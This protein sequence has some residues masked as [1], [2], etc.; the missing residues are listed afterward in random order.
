M[1]KLTAAFIIGLGL[2]AGV[3]LLVMGRT[4]GSEPISPT[5]R[6]IERSPY[7]TTA[8][9][10]QASGSQAKS[11]ADIQS[12]PS[13]FERRAA[14]YARLKSADV[15]AVEILLDEA[16]DLT[17]PRRVKQVIYSR[18]V[19]IDPRAALV[20]LRR[21]ERDQQLLVRTT[22]SAV[23]GSDLDAALAFI[24]TLDDS[25]RTQ[26][27]RNILDLEALS[28]ARKEE[29]AKRFGLERDLLQLQ[30]SRRAK[31]DPAGAWQ[32][33]LATERGDERNAM[34]WSV[35]EVWF[36]TDPL[37]TLSAIASLNAPHWRG[38]QS[39]LVHRW[40]SQDP[41]A[42]L[43]WALARPGSDRQSDPL[44]Q[45]AAE[46]AKH[47]PQEMFDL[48]ETLEPPRRNRV[49]E[50]VLFAWGRIDPVAAL[51]AAMSMENAAHLPEMVGVSI[52]DS[53]AGN[54]P[55][56][57][58][59]WV[60]AQAPSSARSSMLVAT[61][62]NLGESDPARALS[63]AEELDGNARSRSIESVLRTWGVRD[64]LA[65]AAWLDASG[66]K[67]S[68]AVVAVVH[69]FAEEDPVG[70]FEWLQD[71]PVAAQQHGFPI[72]VRQI[73][74]TSPE[75]ALRLI[76]RIRDPNAKQAAG[77][78]LISSWVET[79]PQ[80]AVRAIARMDETVGQPLYGYA[81]QMWSSFDPESATAFLDRIPSSQR[82]GA[83]QGMVQQAA[84][85]D[86][87]LAEQLFDRLKGDESRRAAAALLFR[88]LH[89]IDPE[90]A[91]RYRELSGI[92]GDPR[93]NIGFFR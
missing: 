39:T 44:G 64:P 78:Q 22:L 29:V 70:A 79:D 85:R 4:G 40:L 34:L 50:G 19:Q 55:Q 13:E 12:L 56:A 75:S 28:E 74:A 48:V 46:I 84:F 15:D 10:T 23:A 73:A 49:V 83:I 3:V 59:E 62:A 6:T 33:A 81:F 66:N 47:S 20:R 7:A 8:T 69:N 67:T 88:A 43:E 31:D 77:Y 41:D 38:L 61:L 86:P 37:A 80:E 87:D 14:L 71:Q 54:D 9:R 11:L 5:P 90:R 57:A 16:E 63:L 68:A 82:D 25:L 30:A 72:V 27:A 36:E 53:W 76:A 58:F 1:A 60:R 26:S 24:D 91:E 42:A 65:A 51:D 18:Y 21:E 92:T 45:V 35:A 89:E 2:G 17:S 93:I 52:V 32:T